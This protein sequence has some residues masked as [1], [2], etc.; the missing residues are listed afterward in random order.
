MIEAEGSVEILLTILLRYTFEKLWFMPT[1]L[2]HELIWMV[3]VV[4]IF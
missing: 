3:L 2:K 1:L 4:V